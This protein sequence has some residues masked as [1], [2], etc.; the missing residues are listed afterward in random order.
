MYKPCET[1]LCNVSAC[2]DKK[3]LEDADDAYFLSDIGR[4]SGA[5]VLFDEPEETK[6]F[7][8]NSTMNRITF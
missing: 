5:P 6:G 8:I 3:C 7:S 4:G 1:G 2:E